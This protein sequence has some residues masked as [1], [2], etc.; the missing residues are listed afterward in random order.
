MGA[1]NVP[2]LV[3]VCVLLSIVLVIVIY[4][5]PSFRLR[6]MRTRLFQRAEAGQLGDVTQERPENGIVHVT[7]RLITLK[8]GDEVV[9]SVPIRDVLEV[10]SY[11]RDLFSV[12]LIC[13]G[14]QWED[15]GKE[16]FIELNEEM[17]GFGE[18]QGRLPSLFSLR[19]PE[20]WSEV[21][22]PAFETNY[23]VLWRHDDPAT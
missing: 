9:A 20:W 1:P 6:R 16:F 18:L 4:M 15:A 14:F 8:A 19:D 3:G 23:T 7:D 13:L 21:A 2:S 11:K 10:I 22:F 12:D 5:L 17:A